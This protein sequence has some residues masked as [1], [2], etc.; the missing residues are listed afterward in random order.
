MDLKMKQKF[1]SEPNLTPRQVSILALLRNPLDEI[2]MNYA[3]AI[4]EEH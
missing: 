2:V 3:K 4:L 1:F